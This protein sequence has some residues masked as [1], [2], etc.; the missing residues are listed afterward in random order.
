M[1]FTAETQRLGE[2]AEVWAFSACA[3]F[4]EFDAFPYQLRP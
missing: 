1:P 3:S 2:S 4:P